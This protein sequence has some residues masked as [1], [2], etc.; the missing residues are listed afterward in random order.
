MSQAT[1]ITQN[2]YGIVTVMGVRIR[3]L[4]R[5]HGEFEKIILALRIIILHSCLDIVSEQNRNTAPIEVISAVVNLK[6][7]IHM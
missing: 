3:N 6:T 7:L 2:C 1:S 4:E 5:G